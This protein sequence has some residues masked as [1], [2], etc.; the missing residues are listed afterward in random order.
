MKTCSSSALRSPLALLPI[1]SLVWVVPARAQP[2]SPS[3]SGAPPAD[4]TQTIA[5]PK[6]VAPPAAAPATDSTNAAVSA[7]GQYATGNSKLFAATA[8]GKFDMRRGANGFGAMIVGNYAEGATPPA[9]TWKATTENLQ[10]KLRYDRY[11]TPAFGAFLQ[12]TGTSDV[13]QA[14]LFRLNVDP[15]VKLFFVDDPTT[16]F[17]GEVGY[18]F[19]FDDNY[20]ATNGI[21][22]AGGGGIAFDTNNLPYVI[23]SENTVESTRLFVGF[24]HA[25]NKDVLLSAGLEYLQGLAGTGTGTPAVPNG[26][27]ASQ[28]D[29]VPT[30]V[31][32]A[33]INGD[34]L[35]AAQV[36]GGFSV[37]LGIAE[38]YKSSPLAGKVHLDS[39]GTVSLIY[40]FS[41]PAPA[42]PPC[43]CPPLPPPPPPAPAPASAPAPAPTP[44]PT[45]TPTSA[46]S[47]TP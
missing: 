21:E 42:P 34:A 43:K 24:K 33:R 1:A 19:E 2:A 14:I 15:G 30:S 23:A 32:G 9:T 10:G 45:P 22:L 36:G 20:V 40:S 12:L 8:L 16:K 7:G 44:T 29:L 13:F 18:D 28:V 17:W 37:G 11:F 35:F 39:T 26:Y 5:A 27:A 6:P 47:P 31:T 46:P 3:E 38:K 4:L 25:F 41:S